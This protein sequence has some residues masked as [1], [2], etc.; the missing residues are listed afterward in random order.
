[1]FCWRKLTR[2]VDYIPWKVE[3]FWQAQSI[4]V[5]A[6]SQLEGCKL[7][8]H[9]IHT[10]IPLFKPL[11]KLTTDSEEIPSFSITSFSSTSLSI[12]TSTPSVQLLP[13]LLP[14]LKNR[15]QSH[16]ASK[17][18]SPSR[19]RW[20]MRVLAKLGRSSPSLYMTYNNEKK[21]NKRSSQIRSSTWR[22]GNKT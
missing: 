16:T 21:R 5:L 1:M 10:F 7:K 12:S 14:A 18:L 3:V 15:L 8:L 13:L 11:K 19:W 2:I 20:Q 17:S 22:L 4:S 6:K 9:D